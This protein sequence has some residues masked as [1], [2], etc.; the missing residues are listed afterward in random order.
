MA[1]AHD[2]HALLSQL[3]SKLRIV[4]L[5]ETSG[6]QALVLS[7]AELDAALPDGGLP[8]GVVELA[9]PRAL[10]GS[11]SVALAAVRAGQARGTEAWCAWLDPEATLY[12]PGVVAAGVDLAR[13]LVVRPARV[14]LARAAVKIVASGAFEVVVID[15]DSVP[16][17]AAEQEQK[18][19]PSARGNARDETRGKRA[20]APE[21]LVRKLSLAAESGGSTVLLLTD[22][23][24]RRAVPWP[25]AL[26]IE[27][28]RPAPDE[29]GVR[30]A[31][32]KRGRIGVTKTIS[33][34]P[35][36]RAAG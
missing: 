17:A 11:T 16:R 24:R 1:A 26:R 13:M 15:F 8:Q 7:W 2:V 30:I 20:W 31:K 33:F 22:S 19:A 29:L 9:A 18:R 23:L 25:V 6:S 21:V 14:D 35:I 12:A 4:E 28:S 10:G 5:G 34:L 3:G 32:D 27:L 36:A